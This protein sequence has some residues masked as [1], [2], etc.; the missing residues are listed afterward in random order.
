MQHCSFIVR[1]HLNFFCVAHSNPQSINF[2]LQLAP[3]NVE[4]ERAVDLLRPITPFNSKVAPTHLKSEKP[5]IRRIIDLK[6]RMHQYVVMLLRELKLNWRRHVTSSI[7][8][9]QTN[10]MYVTMRY[11]PSQAL[12]RFECTFALP[13]AIKCSY[14]NLSVIKSVVTE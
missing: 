6:L 12:W 10:L 4:F 11:S 3:K 8:L 2:L 1:Y 14:S 13:P 5:N 7:H 9:E